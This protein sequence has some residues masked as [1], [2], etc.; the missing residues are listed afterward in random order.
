MQ[1]PI[2]KNDEYYLW[3]QSHRHLSHQCQYFH[4]LIDSDETIPP[5]LIIS[6][7]NQLH[8][9]ILFEKKSIFKNIPN[10]SFLFPKLPY[11]HLHQIHHTDHFQQFITFL[12]RLMKRKESFLLKYIISQYT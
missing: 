10:T 5:K 6:F 2:W 3:Y 1:N 9:H 11:Q 12:L 4:E 8:S 7:L